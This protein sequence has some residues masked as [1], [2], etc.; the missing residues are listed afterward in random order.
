LP[1]LLD[2]A[3]ICAFGVHA[4]PERTETALSGGSFKSSAQKRTKA[5]VFGRNQQKQNQKRKEQ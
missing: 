3:Q 2:Q 1:F 5:V 4:E